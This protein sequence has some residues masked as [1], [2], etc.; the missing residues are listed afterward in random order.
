[1]D[2]LLQIIDRALSERG[3]SA[4]RASIEAVGTPN[5]V[6]NM[7]RGQ[8]PSVSRLRALCE[9]LGL[10]FYIGPPRFVGRAQFDAGRL[11]LALD[12]VA[13]GFPDADALPLRD[14]AHLIVAVYD[15]IDERRSDAS[16]ARAREM[17]AIARRFGVV[18]AVGGVPDTTL[19]A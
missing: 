11:A 3:C 15:I 1:M 8:E 7:R 18:D 10:E 5:L 4:R 14:R 17:I 12:V 13:C 19:S 2:S 6:S 9:V 16:A